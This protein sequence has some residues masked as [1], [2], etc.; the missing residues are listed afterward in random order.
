MVP[1]GPDIDAVRTLKNIKDKV[2]SEIQKYRGAQTD[3]RPQRQPHT[4]DFAR[5]ARRISGRS[6]GLVLGGG[7]ARGIA[8]LV[9]SLQHRIHSTN[10]ILSGFNPS[11]GGAWY[12]HRPYWG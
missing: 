7:G 6:I 4:N 10:S 3:I 12:T 8:H 9:I 11:H 1:K 2:Q 5:L